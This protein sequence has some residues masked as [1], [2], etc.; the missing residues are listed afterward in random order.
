MNTQSKLAGKAALVT[1]ASKGIGAAI[2]KQLAADGASVIVNYA[3]DQAGADRTVAA[4]TGAGGKALAIQANI[5]KPD[6]VSRLVEESAKAFGKLDIVVNNAGV[7]QFE[8][9]EELTPEQFY[10]NFDTNVLGL[11][12]TTKEAVRHFPEEGGSVIH[13][14]SVVATKGFANNAIYSA[15]KGAVDAAT[16][17]L[18][19]ELGPRGIRVN[20]ISPGMVSTEGS[21]DFSTGEMADGL[22]AITPLRRIGQPEDIAPLAS[23]LASS[24]ASWITGETYAVSGGFR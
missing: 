2:A 4:I 5:A 1:G 9:L 6:E 24:D 22:A 10:R 7:Y 13:I 15:T 19:A 8:T 17:A 12:L 23:F 3:T 21:A 18:A 16:R 20:A 11:L 14:S